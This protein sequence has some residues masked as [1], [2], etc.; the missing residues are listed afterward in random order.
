MLKMSKN[1]EQSLLEENDEKVL[2]VFE[3][4]SDPSV[5]CDVDII[6]PNEATN[7]LDVPLALLPP[8]HPLLQKFQQSLKEYLLRTRDKLINE[9]EEIKYSTKQKEQEREEQGAILYDMQEDIMRQNKQLETFEEQIQDHLQKRHVEEESVRKLKEEYEEKSQ[10]SKEQKT[11]YNKRMAELENMQELEKNISRWADD[12]EDEVKNAKRV[13][14]RD[15]QLQQ[16]LSEEKKKSDLLSYHLD[17][18]V[19]RSEKELEIVQNEVKDMEEVLNVLGMSVSNANA[20]LEALESEHKRL[21]QAWSEVI[22]AI[23]LRD[24]ILYQVQEAMNK[25]KESI[26]LSTAG[27]QAIQKQIQ[28]ELQ[29][30][31]K[32]EIFKNRLSDDFMVLRRQCKSQSDILADLEQKLTEV[33]IMLEQTEKDLKEAKMEG[34]NLQTEIHRIQL[35][36]DK[37]YNKKY[38]TEENI[39]KLAQEQLINDKA[40]EYRLKLLNNSQEERRSME[41][42]LTQAQNQLA[43]T[44]LEMERHKANNFRKSQENERLNDKL[45][46]LERKSDLLNMELKQLET[47]IE[48]K[49][50]RMD[51]LNNQL[52]ELLRSNEGQ[53]ISPTEV[54]IKHLE[55]TVH[56]KDQQLRDYQKYWIMFQNHYV[57]LSQKRSAQMSQIQITRKQLS[58]IKQKSLKLDQELE[59]SEVNTKELNRDIQIYQ[60]KLEL[61]NARVAKKRQHH[62]LV[63]NECEQ[64]HAELVEKLKDN[65]MRVLELEESINELQIEIEHYKDEVLDKHR[66]SLSW[67]TKYKLIEETLRWRREEGALDS[68]L[69]TM[70]TEIHRMQI[71]HQQLKRAQEKLIQDLDHCV[72]H[73]EHIS[74]TASS[75]QTMEQSKPTAARQSNTSIKYKINDL[76]N[77]LKQIQSE[78]TL[79]SDQQSKQATKEYQCIE[80]DI[81]RL[82]SHIEQETAEDNKIRCEIEAGMLQK[83]E[84]LENIIRKQ[85]RAKSYRRLNAAAQ[86][87]KLP[88]SEASILAQM[89]KQLEMNDHLI[90]AIQSLSSDHPEKQSFFSKLLHVLKT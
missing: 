36:I 8:D 54:K 52:D 85:N 37:E 41:L 7:P 28:K 70:R 35:K 23:S 62:E 27:M 26:K 10:M 13:V 69:G 16:E 32:L 88:R 3:D 43:E 20:D 83:H 90:D 68:E 74:V 18:E 77:K 50:K 42:N 1:K 72:M 11:K 86:P 84:N 33:P 64:E 45:L 65:E 31:E 5:S 82:R 60:S 57:N 87:L 47:Q 51:K 30:N 25:E 89:Q 44:L 29:L 73:R 58:I 76:R 66:E 9:I 38:E 67:E 14:S 48:I 79:I 15:A 12:V 40:S 19:K 21:S 39:L 46:S 2:A 78:I 53:E 75:K 55:K 71:R 4:D 61:L 6:P 80:E 22:V 59:Q 34:N 24:R 17:V 63:E 81:K 49:I 56:E